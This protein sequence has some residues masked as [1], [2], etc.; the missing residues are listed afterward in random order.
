[1]GEMKR[2]PNCEK[3]YETILE[4]KDDRLIQDQYPNVPKWQREQLI[5]GICSD[6][7]W[8]EHLG[9]DLMATMK[10]CDVC[11]DEGKVSMAK[12]RNGLRGNSVVGIVSIDVCEAHKNFHKK[13]KT[14]NELLDWSMNAKP[15]REKPV[16]H[17]D[18]GS[19][20]K[21]KTEAM[22]KTAASGVSAQGSNP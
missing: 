8:K 22:G 4:R 17:L 15:Y 3:E 14:G 9:V 1:M 18:G 19:D 21:P 10:I 11:A 16:V 7:C 6:K 20:V 2:C 5:S 13:F 12:W